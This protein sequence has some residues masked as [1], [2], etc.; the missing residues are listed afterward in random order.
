LNTSAHQHE[1]VICNTTPIRY[2]ALV[3]QFDLL[4]NIFGGRVLVPR[5]VLDLEEDPEGAAATSLLSEIGR[6]ERYWAARSGNP[7]G[8][9][10]WNRLRRV[11][12]RSDVEIVDLDDDELIVYAKVTT[13]EFA[14]S[15]GLAGPLGEGEAAVI[16][17][18]ETRGWAAALDESAARRVIDHRSPELQVLTSRDL[19]RQAVI[20]H[21]LLDSPEAQI[22]YED[23]LADGY[24][25][26]E[27]LWE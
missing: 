15:L 14:R 7:E 8:M 24:R 27:H 21:S 25:G 11:R 4:V 20:A 3:G 1:P 16:A 23:M 17:I 2:F 22:V 5:Q 6:S 26:P 18:A 13:A 9:E 19:L 10:R 12:Q